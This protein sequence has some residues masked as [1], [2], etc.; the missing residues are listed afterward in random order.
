VRLEVEKAK[1]EDP[2]QVK[3]YLWDLYITLYRQEFRYYTFDVK[4][5]WEDGI[6]A[7]WEGRRSPLVDILGPVKAALQWFWQSVL[8]PPLEGLFSGLKWAFDQAIGGLKWLAEGIA[9]SLQGLWNL[10]QNV[11]GWLWEKISGGLQWLGGQLQVVGDW[12]WNQVSGGLRWVWDNIR[13]G[14]EAIGGGLKWLWEQLKGG[15]EWVYKGM[16]ATMSAISEYIISGLKGVVS[17]FERIGEW[18]WE[19]VKRIIVEPIRAGLEA[20]LNAISEFGQSI[21]NT[22][23]EAIEPRSPAVIEGTWRRV[24]GAITGV[25][26]T[27]VVTEIGIHIENALHPMKNLELRQTRDMWLHIAGFHALLNAFHTVYFRT[28]V[29]IPLQYELNKLWT[30]KIPDERTILE[31]LSRYKITPERAHELM[32]YHGYGPEWDSW[33][34]ELANTPLSPTMLRYAAY[35]GTLTEDFLERELRRRGISEE[36]VQQFKRAF[37]FWA[38]SQDIKDCQAMIRNLVKEGFISIQEARDTYAAFRS[39]PDPLERQLFVA[40]LAYLYDYLMD[41]KALVLEKFRRGKVTRSEALA[42]LTQFM[43]VREKAELLLDIQ[44]AKMKLEQAKA[45]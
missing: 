41:R 29:E 14:L 24:L 10:V 32:R 16:A 13:G 44:E 26:S 30:P 35:G 3:R 5:A 19:G 40:Q 37:K 20:I 11:G 42:E 28:S 9:S 45:S 22:I 12:I 39:L 21:W 1:V 2:E 7:W 33:W 8:K 17:I 6:R 34:D 43:A 25:T 15:L 18:I 38:D 4:Q 27:I 23:R 36:A 31:M